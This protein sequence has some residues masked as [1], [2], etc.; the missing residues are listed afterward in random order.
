MKA[1]SSQELRQLFLDFFKQEGHTLV[2]SS[3]LVPQNDSTLLFTN[4]GM[5]QFKDVFLGIEKRPY[6]RAV[7]S[8]RCVRAGGK[9][10]DLEQV[11]YTARHHTFFE[12]LGNFSF[13][14]YFKREAIEYSWRFLTEI[15][16]IPPER[17]WITVFH[18]D[19]ETAD[20][21][22]KDRKVDAERFSRCGKE[23]NFWSMGNTGPCGPCTEIFYDHGEAVAGGPPGTPE[24]EGDR[25]V[26]IWNM[27]FMQYDRL[28]TGE[29]I[30][31]PA[32]SVDTGM[33][34][35]RLTAILQGVHNNFDTDLFQP[36]IKHVAKLANSC[37][38]DNISM[39]VIAD[40]IRSAAFLILD[41]ITPGNEGRNYVLRRIIR[42]AIRH[43]YKLGIQETF[44]YR[45]IAPF[46]DIMRDGYPE[47]V[48]EQ[49]LIE[50]VLKQE[51]E[52]F[53]QT[54]TQGLRMFEQDLA[55]MHNNE[56]SGKTIFRLYDTYGFP[57][58]LTA[59]LANERNLTLDWDGFDREMAVQ[60]ARAKKSSKFSIDYHQQLVINEETEFHGYHTTEM[61]TRVSAIYVEHDSVKK[62]K[63]DQVGFVILENTPFYAESGGQVGDSGELIADNM[64]FKVEDTQYAKKAIIHKGKL[65]QG[66]L[67]VGESIIAKIDV[68]RRA[69][70]ALNHSATHLLHAALRQLLGQHV[71]QK[72]S[73]VAMERL[74]FDFS[75]AT[76]LSQEELMALEKRVNAEIQANYPVKTQ[77][78][79][80]E[81]A[82]SQGAMA[83]F[84]E[85]YEGQVRVLSMGDFSVE[86]CGGTHAN[87]TGDIGL[88]KIISETGVAAGIRRIEAITG[89]T[90][91]AY[92]QQ[93][94]VI[95]HEI[96]NLLQ[97]A[98]QAL[99][100][101]VNQ[102]LEK[103]SQ[104]SKQIEQI[105]EQAAQHAL[106]KAFETASLLGEV[107]VLIHKMADMK[108]KVLRATLET[109]MR[110]QEHSVVVLASSERDKVNLVVGI[111]K[112]LTHK[113]TAKELIN[114]V[115]SIVGGKGGG[116]P[117]LAQAG[118]NQPENLDTALNS[119]KP[120]LEE[121]L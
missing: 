50:Q 58:D 32:Q 35:E 94:D 109:F 49:A 36:I 105:R 98:W 27:V 81:Q 71:V 26:E 73:L 90:A 56:V 114:H 104:L 88:F 10:N 33:G 19:N 96:A 52:R 20:I 17:L 92:I 108:A 82:K 115:S 119:V 45:L 74:R 69:A 63:K 40:H 86:L 18:E 24:Q 4:A 103:N 14:D 28:S 84:G 89:Q 62:L 13:G 34:L 55:S 77:L 78:M 68:E 111:S 120:W 66:E 117:E 25:Y 51:E 112:T 93:S 38:Y 47:L 100:Q 116:K 42:R 29:L 99:P 44:F 80:A 15:L 46:V 11:G 85:K 110:N 59:D 60:K 87:A 48:K 23:D 70:I 1:L 97:G 22:L 3:S 106:K 67:C 43:G 8:Q 5:V 31:L 107:K 7:S 2:P 57:P 16:S 37:Q 39:R 113:I 79:Q 83:L 118:G 102:L 6:K 91:L 21:W 53:S 95:L 121:H 41:G 101:K 65:M 54:L 12:M 72:G 61:T 30:S 9:H 76:P 75:H 64:Q